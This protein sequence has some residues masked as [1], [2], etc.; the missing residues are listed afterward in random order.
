MLRGERRAGKEK[1]GDAWTKG[2]DKEIKRR[3]RNEKG[4]K[5]DKWMKRNEEGGMKDGKARV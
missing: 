2:N 5:E 4:M 3:K 1:R